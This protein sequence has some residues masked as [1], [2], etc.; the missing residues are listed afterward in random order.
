MSGGEGGVHSTAGSN[1]S[2]VGSGTTEI[3]DNDQLIGDN[4]LGS[5]IVGKSSSNG[6]VDE[7]QDFKTSSLSGSGQGLALG[8]IEVGRNGDDGGV[9]LLSK[10]LSG[11]LLQAAKVT[12]S[13]LGDSDS[14]GGLALGVADGERNGRVGLNWVRGVVAWGGVY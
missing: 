8:I 4:S 10:V 13:N 2:S 11:R 7:L 3:G 6:F 12:G 9:D 5:G 1:N 14:V